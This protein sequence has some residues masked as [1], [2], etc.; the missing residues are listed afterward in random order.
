[1]LSFSTL[2]KNVP[3]YLTNAECEESADDENQDVQTTAKFVNYSQQTPALKAKNKY[4]R[5]PNT[6]GE[7]CN[8]LH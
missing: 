3:R 2:M 8:I 5:I 6:F 7:A 4:K 1:M